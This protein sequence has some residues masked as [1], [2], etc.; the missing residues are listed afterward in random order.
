MVLIKFKSKRRN[1]SLSKI[2][3]K[4]KEKIVYLQHKPNIYKCV[5]NNYIY[6]MVKVKL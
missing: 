2:L 4:F 3:W 1:K 6:K 5:K